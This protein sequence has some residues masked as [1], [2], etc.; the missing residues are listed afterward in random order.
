MIQDK[1][2]VRFSGKPT[3]RRV[4]ITSPIMRQ[5]YEKYL[6]EEGCYDTAEVYGLDHPI[7]G[8]GTLNTSIVVKKND[9]GSFETL[10]TLY[11]PDT[12]EVND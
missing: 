3:F 9:D 5:E 7:L 6:D 1:P 8:R 12:K 4:Q 10:N 11:V 2:T